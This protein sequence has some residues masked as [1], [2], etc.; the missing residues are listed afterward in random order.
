RVLVFAK[1]HCGAVVPARG[2][3]QEI[4]VRFLS[5][6][7]RIVAEAKESYAAF[8]VR[9]AS[10]LVMELSQLGNVYFDTKR[11]WQD[12]KNP[13]TRHVMETTIACC[14]ECLK[15]MA[16]IASPIIPDS[17]SKI[18]QMLGYAEGVQERG[19]DSIIAEVV[20]VGQLLREPQILFQR[21][22]DA[23]IQL[24]IERL[25]KMSQS[26]IDE[27]KSD[28]PAVPASYT[29]LKETVNIGDVQRLDL[30]VGTVMTAEPVPKSKKLLKLQI[31]LGFELRTVV[32]GIS[33]NYKPEE[34][35]GK[36][37]VVV[38]NLQPA[39][40]MGIQ[41]QGMI[42]AGSWSKDLELLSVQHLPNGSVVS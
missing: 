7:Q 18:W 30:R 41:S 12:A 6:I 15:S 32:S 16:L 40:L 23:Q 8:K 26:Q 4:D 13:E 11:P 22:E 42:L 1:I 38:A 21:V 3:L 33:Q 9:Q 28:L 10:Q 29:P 34:I 39:T 14:L 19:W 2:N 36:K 37:V 27:Q 25:H 5:E 35:I 31:D 24:E 20:P 17:A